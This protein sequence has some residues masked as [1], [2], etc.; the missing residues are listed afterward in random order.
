MPDFFD[1]F[2]NQKRDSM[3]EEKYLAEVARVASLNQARC[4]VSSPRVSTIYCRRTG[5]I[6]DQ[7]KDGSQMKD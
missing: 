5:R 2:E 3:N 4:F 7:W 1:A 6:P